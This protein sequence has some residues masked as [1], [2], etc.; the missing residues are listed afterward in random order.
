VPTGSPL[1][2]L[3]AAYGWWGKDVVD[4]ETVHP[5]LVA[6]RD[7]EPYPVT[8]ALVPLSLVLRRPGLARVGA[9]RRLVRAAR[10]LARARR[11]GARLRTVTHRGVPTAAIVYDALPVIDAFRRVSDDRVLGLMDARGLDAPF[12][13]ELTRVRPG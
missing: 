1:D 7:G 4:A 12:A 5:L 9:V 13:F 6:D 11:P 10:P 8:P 3:L 2:G